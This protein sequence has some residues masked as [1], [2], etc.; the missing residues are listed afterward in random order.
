[1]QSRS[2][3]AL[4]TSHMTLENTKYLEQLLT[5]A[6]RLP[7]RLSDSQVESLRKYAWD[8]FQLHSS[9]RIATFNFYITLSS[10]IIAGIGTT[11]QQS[12]NLPAISAVLGVILM[13]ISFVFWK[14]DQRNKEMIKTAEAALKQLETLAL[15]GY[16]D[17]ELTLNIFQHDER[18]VA[19]K[20]TK[21]SGLFW[22][23][24]Y[25]YT[26]CFNIIFSSFGVIGILGII[27]SLLLL[28][29]Y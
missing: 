2:K 23:N 22:R 11:L 1:M 14:L 8:Y 26:N 13:L 15:Y 6:K 29:I 25:S 20:K 9:Q 3:F 28:F 4:S 19:I 5:E 16:K 7:S 27:L 21:R 24:H 17:L 18:N 12:I 10:A